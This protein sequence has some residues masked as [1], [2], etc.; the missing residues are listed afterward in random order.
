MTRHLLPAALLATCAGVQAVEPPLTGLLELRWGDSAPGA[1]P[2][3]I[4]DVRL[5][6]AD[7]SRHALDPA[8]ALLGAGN[9][10][11]LA[12]REVAVSALPGPWP[13]GRRIV[14]AIVPASPHGDAQPR[15]AGSQPWVTLACK[16][17]DVAAEPQSVA[18]F[19]TMLSNQPGRLDH[20]WRE[21]SY[22][23]IDIEG[24]VAHG[25]FTL[26]HPRS[27][28]VPDEGSA[29][30]DALFEDC[31]AVADAG[32]H[33]PDYV[34]VNLFFN[35]DLDGYAWGG[36]MFI[37]LDGVS[38]VWYATWEPPWGYRHEAPLGHEMGHGFGLPHANNSDADGDP[39]DN[40]WDVMSD[41]WSNA[42][43]SAGATYGWLPKHIGTWSRD[44]LDWI[45]AA[46]KRVVAS[47]G[48]INGIVLDRASLVGSSNVQMVVVTLPAPEPASH[49][50]V[51]E[52]RK[53]VGTY[54]AALAGDAVIIHEVDTTRGEP[55]WSVDAS[56]PPADTSNNEGSMFK[57]GE[58]W[59]AP[60]GAFTV[61]VVGET[62]D[63]FVLDLLRG[64]D[65]DLI[66][67]DGF[68]G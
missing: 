47:D 2:A 32:V 56:V 60:G 6:G 30:L 38:R 16:F 18:Y 1:A 21:V 65:P 63:G 22:N 25:W 49:Y 64:V 68:E 53:R 35:D 9:L 43:G 23:K 34:G 42:T 33:F 40:P 14:E 67:R 11:K 36:G 28:Y 59:T 58:S 61:W 13:G 19:D 39:Y 20:Y 41:A 10:Y 17:A 37:T 27:H 54:E 29:D 62:S 31:A 46:R 51:I 48:A 57:V 7:G 66:F 55:A 15:I 26:P 45:D 52:A 44:H 4:F 50:Y 3:S 12:G 8:S 5:A 24:S